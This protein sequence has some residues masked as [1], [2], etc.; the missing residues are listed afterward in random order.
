MNDQMSFQF[1]NPVFN[2]FTFV[3]FEIIFLKFF[4]PWI[5]VSLYNVAILCLSEILSSATL[6]S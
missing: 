2:I 4:P 1:T 6:K 5:S 3:S